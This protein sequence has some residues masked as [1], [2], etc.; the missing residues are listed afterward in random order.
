MDFEQARG[1]RQLAY[2]VSHHRFERNV[3]DAIDFDARGISIHNEASP[4]N[5]R[6]PLATNAEKSWRAGVEG[7]RGIRSCVKSTVTGNSWAC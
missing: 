3:G 2:R 7:C 5:G 4:G 6:K 1:A